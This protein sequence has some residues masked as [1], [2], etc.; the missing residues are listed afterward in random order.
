MRAP[1]IHAPEF[2]AGLT[3]LNVP[4]PSPRSLTLRELRGQVVILDFWTYC[5]VNCMHVIPTLRRLEE[6]HAKDPV[7]VIG[8]HSAKFEGEKDAARI[9]EAMRRYDVRHPVV[10]DRDMITWNAFAVRSWP[11]LIVLRPDGTIAAVAPGEPDPDVLEQ[12]VAGELQ[13]ARARGEL[14]DAPVLEYAPKATSSGALSY[15]G[16]VAISPAG[17]I[18]VSDSGHQRVLVLDDAGHVTHTVGSG[19]AGHADGSLADA[20]FEDPQGIAWQSASVLF[21]ADARTHT[22]RRVDLA[23]ETVTTIAGTGTIGDASLRAGESTNAR[24]TALRSPWDVA[25][26]G[27]HLYVAL[28]GSHQIA[29]IDLKGETISHLAGTGAESI[30]DGPARESTFSQPSGLALHGR[31]LYIA[32][33]ETSAV[34]A[35][36][37]DAQIVRTIVGTGLFDFGDRDGPRDV[38]L[39]QHDVGLAMNDEGVLVVADTYNHK[40]RT[41]DRATGAVKTLLAGGLSEPT[42]VTWDAHARGWLVADTNHHR[43]VRVTKDG[44]RLAPITITGAPDPKAGRVVREDSRASIAP[45]AWFTTQLTAKDG[46]ALAPGAT[47][48]LVTVRA[49]E[50]KK[51]AAGATMGLS[52]EVSRR[53]DLL[54]L[55]STERT[56]AAAGGPEEHITLNAKVSAFAGETIEAEVVVRVDA[57]VCPQDADAYGE[58]AVCEPHREW[59]RLPVRLAKNGRAAIELFRG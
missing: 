40:L 44:I 47:K 54:V 23:A 30:V 5:C 4:G 26:D 3:W 20:A 58:S 10:V 11:T 42:G 35:I 56:F 27:D 13:R 33:S 2:P 59:L 7:V 14:A 21:V 43:L 53:S 15:P 48:I 17:A 55:D 49:P 1:A 41:V 38:A 37:L 19:L 28:A 24:R 12:V 36:D 18:A 22:V 52:C 6:R 16:K 29:T 57:I 39:L 45:S 25:L 34:R 32:D 31:T 51:F 50:G 9:E 46:A 8:V